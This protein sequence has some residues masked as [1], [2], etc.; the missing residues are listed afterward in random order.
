MQTEHPELPL[1]ILCGLHNYLCLPTSKKLAKAL[2][3]TEWAMN[4]DYKS[5][6]EKFKTCLSEINDIYHEVGS[7]PPE[8]FDGIQY[9]CRRVGNKLRIIISS[10]ASYNYA[11]CIK[12]HGINRAYYTL[13]F[14]S[15]STTGEK[16]VGKNIDLSREYCE[17]L[18]K[19]NMSNFGSFSRRAF[20]RADVFIQKN[21][22]YEITGYYFI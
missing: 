15:A 18:A 13:T 12:G 19:H 3:S 8:I 22:E 14:I 5:H 1:E 7:F 4:P 17:V 16:I 20:T 2:P 21:D 10:A 6:V 11:G 9:T